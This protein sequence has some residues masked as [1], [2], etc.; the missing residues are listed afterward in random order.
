M[1]P[2]YHPSY[3]YQ[4]DRIY[5]LLLLGIHAGWMLRASALTDAWLLRFGIVGIL[6]FTGKEDASCIHE[7]VGEVGQKVSRKNVAECAQE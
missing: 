3:Q 2:T 4:P 6:C 7:R 5:S 1:V